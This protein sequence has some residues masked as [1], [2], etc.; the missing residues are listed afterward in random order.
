M[1]GII[2]DIKKFALFDGPGIRTTVFL[3]GCPLRCWWCHNPESIREFPE[4]F[5]NCD[6]NN[7]KENLTSGKKISISDLIIEI[8]KDR[9]FYEESGGGATF[10][11]GEP[12]V[13]IA[14]LKEALKRCKEEDIHTSV[15]TTGYSDFSNFDEIYPATDHFLYDLKIIDPGK[16][17]DFT[18]VPNEK[19]LENLKTLDSMGNK[20]TVRIPLIPGITDTRENLEA[21][22]DFVDDLNN[23]NRIDLLPYNKLGESKYRRFAIENKLGPMKMQ[24]EP[25]LDK[26]KSYFNSGKFE[27]N[28]R[29]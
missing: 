18:G 22:A 20:V 21:I 12:L 23:T 25:E 4:S 29:G 19:I 13:Q 9:I 26:I 8:V 10:S 7:G 16:H 24:A 27:V 3:K 17:Q 14:F 1:T 6:D 15:D 28:I 11:G 2:F 5:L